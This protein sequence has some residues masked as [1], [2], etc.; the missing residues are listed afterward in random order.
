MCEP[1]GPQQPRRKRA[2]LPRP[3]GAA[4]ALLQH[5]LCGPAA[6]CLNPT[7]SRIL[8]KAFCVGE[9]VPQETW[10]GGLCKG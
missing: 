7:S 4:L 1:S 9:G 6:A 2:V 8:H 10:A 5:V 3:P